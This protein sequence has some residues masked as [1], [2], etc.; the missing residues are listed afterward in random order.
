MGMLQGR[1]LPSDQDRQRDLVP[2]AGAAADQISN[3]NRR[4][5]CVHLRDELAEVVVGR[6]P[7]LVHQ[8]READ[9]GQ[10]FGER[11]DLEHGLR[12]VGD[13]VFQVGRAEALAVDELTAMHDSDGTARAIPAVPLREEPIHPGR[14]IGGQAGGWLVAEHG[15]A[16]LRPVR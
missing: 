10:R 7:P 15:P 1:V 11:R 8:E 13:P 5:E 9:A 2:Q 16:R 12:R 6:D 4:I 14:Q 3:A